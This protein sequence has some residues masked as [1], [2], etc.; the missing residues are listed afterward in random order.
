MKYSYK[1]IGAFLLSSLLLSGCGK[2]E[3]DTLFEQTGNTAA[4]SMKEGSFEATFFAHRPGD[5][6]ADTRAAISGK[7]DRVQTLLYILY[8]KDENNTYQ[9]VKHV[10]LFRPDN[11]NVAEQHDWPH[12]AVTE[13]LPNGDYKVVF[14]GNLDSNLF[15][16]QGTASVLTDY[17]A[18]YG[19]ARINMPL[20]GPSAFTSTNMYYM[21]V[22]DFNQDSPDVSIL[23]QRIV[24][25]H[26]YQREF[27]DANEAL[28]KLVDNIAAV[29]KEEQLTTEI[30]GGLLNS[31]LLKPVS[32]ALGL[33][34]ITGVLTKQVVDKLVGALVGDLIDVLNKALLQELLTRL[35]STL[36]AQGG[37][38]DLLGLSNL[39]NPWT[40]SPSADISG[41]FV[42]S[43]DFDLKRQS[44]DFNTVTWE[45][46]PMQTVPGEEASKTRYL[47]VTL[48][49]GENLVEKIDI[50]K[51]G[52]TGPIVDGVV[53][54]ALLYGRLINIENDLKYEASA[55]VKYHTDYALLNLTLDNYATSDDSEQVHLTG[56]LDSAL[57]TEALLEELLGPLGTVVGGL[58][59]PILKA[60]TGVLDTTTFALDVKLPNLGIQNIVIEGGWEDT[61]DSLNSGK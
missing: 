23:L 17:R 60:V 32:N 29:I 35:E 19:E 51:E 37:D 18:A 49:N 34:D 1:W 47:S 50:K 14:L 58:L 45:N 56:K 13:T 44:G 48:L 20:A 55:N 61:T 43:V 10:T 59:T 38:A 11:Y 27:V 57:V 39:L 2:E 36:K 26:E 22:A 16:G 25:R 52:L 3:S 5:G 12:E 8:R 9:Y 54:D 33:A 31:A 21:A 4:G 53:D 46:I 28:S 41:K 6:A 30:V 42:S 7:S 24:T 40:I 15:T